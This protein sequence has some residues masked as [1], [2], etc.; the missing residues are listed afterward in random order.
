MPGY[1]TKVG[2]ARLTRRRALAAS[3]SGALAAAF[4]AAC[5]G[6]DGDNGNAP[7]KSD[8]VAV[9]EDTSKN[10]KR[11][12]VFKFSITT[13]SGSWDP[14]VRGA[15]FGTLGGIMFSRLTVVKVN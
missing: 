3:S 12:G 13:D 7:P 11:G 1:W 8:L 10:A 5:G 2:S 4:L 9:S 15:W 6:S 14:H